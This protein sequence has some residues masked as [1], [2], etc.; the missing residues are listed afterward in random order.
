MQRILSIETPKFMKKKVKLSGWVDSRRDHG[1]IIFIDLRDRSGLCQIV[2]TPKHKEV[3][4]KAN[5]LR[6][7]WVISIVGTVK[8]RPKGMEN[9]KIPLGKIEISVEELEI[10]SEAET[11][12]FEISEEESEEVSLEKRLNWRWIDLRMPEKQLIFKVWT[13]MEQAFRNYWLENKYIQIH[14]PKF[15]NAASESG[16]ELFEVLY[17][18]RKAYLAQSPQFYKQMAMAAGFEKIFE[19]G[20]VFRAEPS[21]TPRHATEYIGY[22]AEISFINSYQDII[23]EEEKLLVAVLTKIKN[24][25]GEEISKFY[26]RDL[27]VPKIPFPQMTMEEAKEVLKKM[28]VPSKKPGDISPEEEKKICEFIK[29][30]K[31]HE[32]VF[33]TEYPINERPFYHMRSEENP[34]ITDGFDLLW[35]GIEITTGSQREHRYDILIKQAKEKGIN[36]KSIQHY[37][38]F[39]KFGCPPHGGLGIGPARMIMK[40]FNLDNIREATFLHRGVKRLTP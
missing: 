7:E 27:V 11:P 25:F 15:M 14:S 8:E 4:Q 12:P 13:I 37:F 1:K 3:Y 38:D 39:F 36:I 17:F 10:L 33:I 26:K 6:S 31:G 16:A 21:F 34:K 19:I 22:D 35:N 28:N 2:F 40:I 30:E 32:F 18:D 29:K 5:E 20:P 23:K 24:E 9:P